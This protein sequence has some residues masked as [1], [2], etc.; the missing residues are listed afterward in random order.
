MFS[1]TLDHGPSTSRIFTRPRSS[2]VVF[3]VEVRELGVLVIPAQ[4][5]PTDPQGKLY[6]QSAKLLSAKVLERLEAQQTPLPPPE[7][8]PSV[9]KGRKGAPPAPSGPASDDVR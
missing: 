7:P 8:T 6:P 2:G 5:G 1:V 3:Y 9:R 4:S